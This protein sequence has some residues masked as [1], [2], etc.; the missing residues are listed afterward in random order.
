[1]LWADVG[2]TFRLSSKDY[3]VNAVLCLA[4]FKNLKKGGATIY[5]I[6]LVV[7][8]WDWYKKTDGCG[9]GKKYRFFFLSFF[10]HGKSTCTSYKA[11]KSTAS[12]I[13]PDVNLWRAKKHLVL[14]S[15]RERGGH[16]KRLFISTT[17]ASETPLHRQA[18]CIAASN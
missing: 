17:W 6:L 8:C 2:T 3:A 18:S 4:I 11:P 7:V 13:Q 5:E 10:E 15:L 12:K 14:T 9:C 16:H 1:V